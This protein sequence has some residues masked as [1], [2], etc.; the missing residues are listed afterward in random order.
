VF[1]A[2]DLQQAYKELTARGVQFPYRPSSSR[3]AGDRCSP[4]PTATGPR[5]CPVASRPEEHLREEIIGRADRAASAI[6][7]LRPVPKLNANQ[8]DHN[9]ATKDGPMLSS[10][11]YRL[12]ALAV[13]MS[14]GH[15][16][17]HLIRHH[18]VGWPLT[19]QVHA[20]TVSL[21]VCPVIATGL[22][23]Y[24]TGRVRPGLLWE[25]NPHP[26]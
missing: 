6:G 17:D 7:H 4:T 14:L 3:S 15:H 8:Q 9:P 16:L 23:G 25:A 20:F 13:A 26:A 1:Y 21:I 5:W 12:T 11:L 24:R 22:L 18:A 10:P 2:E 19:D